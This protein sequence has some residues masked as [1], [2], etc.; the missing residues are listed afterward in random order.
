MSNQSSRFHQGSS[1]RPVPADTRAWTRGVRRI[2]SPAPTLCK[3]PVFRNYVSTWQCR[4]HQSLYGWH[5]ENRQTYGGIRLGDSLVEPYLG[6][7]SFTKSDRSVGTRKTD[8]WSARKDIRTYHQ[9]P[10][11]SCG[12]PL[13]RHARP[14][15]IANKQSD[16]IH[17]TELRYLLRTAYF[18]LQE[19]GSMTRK[20]KASAIPT[21]RPT[22]SETSQHSKATL[23]HNHPAPQSIFIIKQHT[24]AFAT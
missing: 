18:A 11:S 8:P 2:P 16:I 10:K 20:H 21:T 17:P 12:L 14:L 5:C 19:S 23:F 24:T 13:I 7:E 3:L 1:S 22:I 15:L 9:M 4:D 6:P